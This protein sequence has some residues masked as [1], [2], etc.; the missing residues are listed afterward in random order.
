M[1]TFVLVSIRV[2]FAFG[3]TIK[4]ESKGVQLVRAEVRARECTSG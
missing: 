3:H 1:E 2:Y 4:E